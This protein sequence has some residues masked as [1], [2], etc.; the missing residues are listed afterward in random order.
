MKPPKVIL[1]KN[2][3]PVNKLET[4]ESYFN[5]GN[6]HYNKHAFDLYNEAK[7]NKLFTDL[8]IPLRF[9]SDYS[10]FF[11][12]QRAKPL[13]VVNQFIEAMKNK[14]LNKEQQVFILEHLINWFNG[15]EFTD[16]KGKE[17]SL[18]HIAD[19]LENETENLQPFQK[20]K[21]ETKNTFDWEKTKQHLATLPDI[22]EKIKHL[23]VCKA[24]FQQQHGVKRKDREV[25]WGGAWFDEQCEAEIKKLK[26]ILELET[27]TPAQTNAKAIFKLK[28]KIISKANF[29]RLINALSEIR[30]FANEDGTLIDK[31]DLM[32]AFG[33]LAGLD[34]SNYAKDLNKALEQSE[35]K[36]FEIFETLKR[37]AIE[38]WN[39]KSQKNK[40][41]S[42]TT[43]H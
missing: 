12:T 28:E 29:I 8:E 21:P 32:F 15:T 38:V 33:N 23:I 26:A 5:T 14:K 40:Y 3:N 35:E 2:R 7:K 16:E 41:E 37:I 13:Q 18:E 1:K 19:L 31:K 34:L 17:Y 20:T 36:N 27:T 30:A 4:I 9:F 11:D 10:D 22:I 6:K 39:E 24:E 25:I 43:I 42:P